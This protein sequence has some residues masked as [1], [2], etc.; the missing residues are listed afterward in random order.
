MAR[1]STNDKCTR[2]LLLLLGVRHPEVARALVAR[3]FGPAE[4][5]RGWRL[6]MRMTDGWL[7]DVAPAD[8]VPIERRF[9]QWENY[10]MPVIDLA[11][12]TWHPEV[13]ARVFRN[14]RQTSGIEAIVSVST[15]VDRLDAI[16]RPESEGGFGEEGRRA[17]ALLESRGVTPKVLDQARA[18]MDELRCGQ[19]GPSAPVDEAAFER[20]EE[21]LWR[22]YLEWSGYVRMAVKDRRALRALGFLRHTKKK[23]GGDEG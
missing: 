10:W 20:A 4:L 17:L 21:E 16:A 3:G 5:A 8:D 9:D 6:L 7:D 18:L 15:L 11:L 22:W 1:L 23:D 2:V 19:T 12:R 14:L 13:H